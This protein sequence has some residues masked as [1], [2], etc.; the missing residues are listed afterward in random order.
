[1]SINKSALVVGIWKKII[2]SR[3]MKKM[4]HLTLSDSRL[5][6]KIYQSSMGPTGQQRSEN[7]WESPMD[8]SRWIS[9]I[10]EK[11]G[12]WRTPITK[13]CHSKYDLFWRVFFRGREFCKTF[14][15]FIQ[16]LLNR[17]EGRRGVEQSLI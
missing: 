2:K 7:F 13:D 17:R 16:R 10:G 8:F 1:M 6:L 5:K 9:P 14:K 15:L 11:L 3:K 12:A 4:L